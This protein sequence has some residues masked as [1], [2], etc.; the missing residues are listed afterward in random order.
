MAASALRADARNGLVADA[1]VRHCRADKIGL[2]DF[3]QRFGIRPRLFCVARRIIQR[4]GEAVLA[5]PDA[6]QGKFAGKQ[7]GVKGFIN[8]DIDRPM[9]NYRSNSNKPAETAREQPEELNGSRNYLYCFHC[10]TQ[11]GFFLP[12]PQMK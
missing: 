6:Q 3:K 4:G 11:A 7:R 12:V 8:I 2:P 5:R 10:Q 1:A 9:F